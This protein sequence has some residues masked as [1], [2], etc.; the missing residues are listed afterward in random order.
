MLTK[1]Q[2]E[3]ALAYDAGAEKYH[4]EFACTNRKLGLL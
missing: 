4:G 2:E 3:A 1:T